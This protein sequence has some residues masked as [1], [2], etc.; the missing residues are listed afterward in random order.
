MYHDCAYSEDE[1]NSTNGWN[2]I[3]R[4]SFMKNSS[5]NIFKMHLGWIFR[6]DPAEVRFSLYYHN[7]DNTDLFVAHRIDEMEF[8]PDANVLIDMYLG[9][10]AIGMI[11][12]NWDSSNDDSKCLGIREDNT[13]LTGSQDSYVAKTFYFGGDS[14]APRRM[15]TKF[16]NSWADESGYQTKFNSNDIM[17]WNLSEFV[18]GDNFAYTAGKEIHGSVA[19]PGLVQY[20]SGDPN[21]EHQKCIIQAGASITFT[22]GESVHL[23]PGFHAKDGSYFR[24][25]PEPA[26]KINIQKT[27]MEFDEQITCFPDWVF[28]KTRICMVIRII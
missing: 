6:D 20:H 10:R 14:Q 22:A 28:S 9:E 18:S 12:S 11:I 19:D 3:G 15:R 26:T 16:H 7:D 1:L 4:I 17:T 2:K 23:H 8:L 25:V 27:P 24:A 5:P 21:K 13:S